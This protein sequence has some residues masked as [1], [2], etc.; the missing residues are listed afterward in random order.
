MSTVCIDC[1]YIGPRPSGIG[2]VVRNLIACLP[3]M[4]LTCGSSCYE[5]RC[6]EPG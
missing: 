1:R 2:E 5:T 4:A 3:G 6:V